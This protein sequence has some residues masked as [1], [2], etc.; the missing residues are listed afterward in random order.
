MSSISNIT[1]QYAKQQQRQQKKEYQKGGAMFDFLSDEK[2]KSENAAPVAPPVPAPPPPPSENETPDNKDEPTILENLK[3]ASTVSD[4]FHKC[5]LKILSDREQTLYGSVL[6]L[7]DKNRKIDYQ[8]EEIT[9]QIINKKFSIGEKDSEHMNI[10]VV[11][12]NGGE[13]NTGDKVLN[14]DKYLE[15]LASVINSFHNVNTS[16]LFSICFLSFEFVI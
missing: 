2:N 14:S 8:D 3:N 10:Y 11:F 6:Y 13:L 4:L 15:Y 12:Q 9:T 16:S 5:G 1:Q 7:K